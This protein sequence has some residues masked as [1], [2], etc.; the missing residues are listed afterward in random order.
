MKTRELALVVVFSALWTVLQLSLGHI[1]GRLSIG[2]ISF[3]GTVNR[4]VG[5]LAM[6]VLAEYTVGFGKVTLMTAIAVAITRIQRANVL[7]GLIV[8]SGYVLAGALFD[9][10]ANLRSN[11]GSRYYMLIAAITGFAVIIPYWL[12][13]AYLLG[14]QGFLLA[15]PIYAYSAAKGVI[16]SFM[17]VSIGLTVNRVLRTFSKKEVYK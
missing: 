16:L 9:L 5:W 12:F 3:H 13:K 14:F 6:A 15:F 4:I 10:I 17:G 8:G 7:M 11:K 2:P 1:I